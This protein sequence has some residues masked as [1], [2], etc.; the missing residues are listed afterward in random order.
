MK[1]NILYIFNISLLSLGLVA[2]N[3][4]LDEKP[5]SD[6][7]EEN[8]GLELQEGDSVK[9]KT[10]D[11]AEAGLGGAYSFYKSQYWQLDQYII[12]EGQS[13]NAYA[14]EPNENRYQIDE[15]RVK[16]NNE[17]ATRI[18]GDLYKHIGTANALITWVPKIPDATFSESR[19][20]EIVAEASFMRALAHFNLIRIYGNIPLVIKDI[21]EINLSNIDE[22]YPL[23]FP[24]QSS[25]Q[26]VYEQIIKDLEYA[27]E[28]APSYSDYKFKVTKA[29]ANLVLAEV[30]ATK[31]ATANIDWNKVKQYSSAVVNNPKYELMENYDDLFSAEGEGN[32]GLSTNNLRF[33]NSKESLFEVDYSSWENTGN[34]GAQM[35]IGKGW[36]KFNTP[37]KD[38]VK[39]F[40]TEGDVIRRDASIMVSDVTGAWSDKFWPV[41]DYPFC[42]KLRSEEKGNIILYRLAEAILLQ[43]EAENELGN[44]DGAK[45]LLNRVRNRVSLPNT[46]ANTK[47]AVRLAIEKEH[48]LEFAFEG[49]R[50]YDL[51]R[52]G[53]FIQ[54]MQSCTDHQR[55]YASSL[56]PDRLI[57]PI[58]HSE[59]QANESLIQNPGY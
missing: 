10:A 28:N 44:L 2:C 21:P 5:F 3:D 4:F 1:K 34:W 12:N 9:Y 18:W 52:R 37:S 56:T 7:T 22:M 13:D 15:F 40:N 45:K 41:V 24:E 16:I 17:N 55:V 51:K 47:D 46:T 36:K 43:A 50:W 53:R 20:K 35:L 42:Y 27:I 33:E 32:G 39:A 11:Q 30:Y 49:K 6:L 59:M 57:W 48:R 58:P 19:K 23:L 29:V 14:G 26:I 31:D 54:V 8:L 38:I 25:S